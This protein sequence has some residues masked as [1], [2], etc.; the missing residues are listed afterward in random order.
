MAVTRVG[1]TVPSGYHS[2]GG[3]LSAPTGCS[4]RDCCRLRA[5]GGSMRELK[6]FLAGTDRTCSSL[7]RRSSNTGDG[8][9]SSKMFLS[10]SSSSGGTL[11]APTGCSPR[12]SVGL[13]ES[14]R[15]FKSFGKPPGSWHSKY[16]CLELNQSDGCVTRWLYERCSTSKVACTIQ[17]WRFI[18]TLL[19]ERGIYP[20]GR[21]SLIDLRRT[22]HV[23]SEEYS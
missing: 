11:S 14:G 3:T 2:S 23:W 21:A 10:E 6:L 17:R 9:A 7:T 12:A 18:F 20:S 1:R 22:E 19:H 13:D 15:G 4:P 16:L 5:V 8:F